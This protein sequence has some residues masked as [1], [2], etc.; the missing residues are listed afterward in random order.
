[1]TLN[2]SA[3]PAVDRSKRADCL[4]AP[5]CTYPEEMTNFSNWYAYYQTRMQ[6]MKSSA[7]RAFG[8]LNDGYRVGFATIN[9]NSSKYLAMNK[10]DATQKTSWYATFYAVNPGNS[11]PLREALSHAGRYFA[12]KKPGIFTDDPMEYACQQNFEL[13]TTD[14]YW[15]G[16]DSNV[17]ELDGTTTMRNYDNVDSGFSK[18]GDGAYDGAVAG[19][20]DTLADVA[21]YY[22]MTGLR[23]PSITPNNC[24]GALGSDVCADVV[25]RTAKDTA[26]GL[27]GT[28]HMT[29][30]SLGLA[31]GLMTYQSN[32]ETATTGDFANIKSGATGCSFSG[33][34]SNT[35]NW[36]LPAHDAQTAL[37]DLWHAA[38]NGRGTYYNARDPESLAVGL[39][40]ALAGIN[41]QTAAAS[42]SATSSPV[43]TQT[44]RTI[45][46]STY[47][48]TVWDGEVAARL[49]DPVTGIVA[50]AIVWTAQGQLD[51][52]SPRNI[53]TYDD[54]NALGNHIKDFVYASLTGSEQAYFD[55]KCTFTMLSQCT[56]AILTPAQIASGNSGS[57][58]VQYL[59]GNR[60]LEIPPVF[61]TREHLLGD[62]VNAKPLFIR[63]PQYGFDDAVVPSYVAFKSAQLTRQGTLY[64]GANDGM[65]HAFNTDTGAEMWAYV[66]KI[67]MPNLYKLADTSYAAN[68]QYYVDGSPE[69]MDIYVDATVYPTSGLATGWHTIL[70]G[71]L[72]LGGRGFYAMDVTDPGNPVVLWET[73][74]D[75]ALCANYD[76]D[77]G[78]SYGNP[79]I[80]KRSTDGKWVVLVT[81]GYNNVSPGSG[82][83]TLFVLDAVT[84][85]QL[86]KVSTGTATNPPSGLAK[87]SPWVDSLSTNFTT[88]YLYGAD[89]NGD[90]WRFDLGAV[91]VPG[92]PTVTRIATLKDGSG[93]AQSVTTRPE[94]G[95]TMNDVSNS[96]TGIGNPVIYV[97]TGRLLGY[98]DKSDP[99]NSQIQT[100]YAIKDDLSKT[101]VA[102][103]IGNPRSPN[104]GFNNFVRQY[105]YQPT[106]TTRI[107]STNAMSWTS[108]SGWYVD[109]V[110]T[111][112]ATNLPLVPN[113]SPGERVKLDPHLVSGTL[114]VIS[115][116]PAG[117]ACAIGGTSWVYGFDY[118]SGQ[119]I[120]NH[121]GGVLLDQGAEGSVI[122]DVAGTI[123]EIITLTGGDTV[124][125]EPPTKGTASTR[126]SSWRELIPLIP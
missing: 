21:M 14:G 100:V 124:T 126:Q 39:T 16:T 97:A 99:V 89:L 33:G 31:D 106:T 120:P 91:G 55:N 75:S 43:I 87:L 102:A 44:D 11:T 121:D 118:S 105:L 94:L 114:S 12:G 10:F 26:A 47:R 18:R 30:Y 57:N 110:A 4:A 64:M 42:A 79:V 1:M 45:F 96:L 25:P 83:G 62:T 70:V 15:N 98:T 117:S 48:T 113:P 78:Y 17:K 71:G 63:V 61:R 5:N 40:A 86:N 24:T 52:L 58:L 23:N 116:V 81:S 119:N 49:I 50:P 74:S 112:S 73:C 108:N 95:D 115:S 66:P 76:V 84:G 53:Y 92:A 104:T 36:P 34:G 32:Y 38:V 46:S 59:S 85:A 107:M 80:T 56:A 27:T 69:T 82:K 60:T 109:L 8:A 67:V 2:Y 103:Y 28:Q 54:T 13:I 90:V 123:K 122:V 101:G 19:A 77:M 6:M 51:T 65:L 125:K 88:R 3:F 9:E 41:V 20:T 37:D 93:V 72:G 68:H 29:T 22:Y 7:G 111:D 35:C